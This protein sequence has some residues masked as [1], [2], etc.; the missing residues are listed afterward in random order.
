[1]NSEAHMGTEFVVSSPEVGQL[2]RHLYVA[3]GAEFARLDEIFSIF[4]VSIQ[5]Q[6][7]IV[8]QLFQLQ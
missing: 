2:D 3:V 7:E 6:L 8:A 4:I 1:M 5:C